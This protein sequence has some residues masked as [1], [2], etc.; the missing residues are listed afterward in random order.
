VIGESD[1]ISREY[2]GVII[3]GPKDSEQ[4]FVQDRIALRNDLTRHGVTWM[5]S[6]VVKGGVNL[7]FLNYEVEKWQH[8]N[9]TFFYDVNASLTAP[10]FARWGSGDPGMEESNVQFGAY[11][12][13]DWDATDRLQLN[14]GVRWDAETNMFNNKWVTPDSVRTALGPILTATGRNPEDYFTSGSDDRPMFLGAF[15]PRVG[16]SYDLL[17]TGATV[18]HGGFGVY[19]DREIWNHLIDERFRLNW[20]IRYFDFT[21]TGDPNRIQWDPSYE[22]VAGLQGLV[23]NA[24]TGV[25]PGITSEI[26]LLKNDS[27]PPKSNQFNV[28]VRQTVS[29]VVFGAAYRGVRG[30]NITSWYCARSHSEHGFCEGTQEL[31]S[32]YKVLLSTDEGKTT[33][34]AVDL[35]VEKV[36][37]EGSRWGASLAYT[38]AE[39][40]RKGWDFFTFDFLDDPDAWPMVNSQIEKHRVVASG[41]VALPWD[42]RLSTLAQWGSGVPFN[43][44]D[45]TVGWGPAR[46]VTDWYSEDASNFKQVDLRLHKSFNLPRQGQI[47]I[48]A[49]VINAFDHSNYRSFNQFE[50]WGGGAV[51]ADFRR[52]DLGSAD[53]GRRMQFGLDFR[54]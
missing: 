41:I 31:G 20:I 17:G 6:H 14:L 13:D 11:I 16:F 26:W 42:V 15:Q 3:T 49:E 46:A 33:Y 1:G 7:D 23:D 8:G 36:F 18:L 45:E 12:Q 35:T 32:R 24:G 21:T 28:G 39:G 53:P 9:P 38:R 47:G 37:T 34:D 52:P 40:E 25:N 48:V 4:R 50:R 2:M 5:G 44:V 29:N 43:R 19:Y 27:K 30:S 54:F 51:N 22:S 10:A